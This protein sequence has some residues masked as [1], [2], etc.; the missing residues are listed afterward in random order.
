MGIEHRWNE[1][2]TADYS[3]LINTRPQGLRE[4]RIRNVSSSGL[5]VE[6]PPSARLAD[7][8]H[9]ELIFAP[10]TNH[11]APILRVPALVVRTTQA[12]TGLMFLDT[13]VLAFRTLLTQLLAEKK[14]TAQSSRTLYEQVRLDT[15]QRL[16]STKMARSTRDTV[17]G[18]TES[19]TSGSHL[20]PQLPESG[21]P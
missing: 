9:V 7:N 5:F 16:A 8:A 12:G 13:N 11:V 3:I 20:N 14:S 6:L 21:Q 2:Q 18:V 1:R 10:S 19:S 15:L 17:A 4:A